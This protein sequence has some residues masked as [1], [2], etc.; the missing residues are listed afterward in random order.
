M[1]AIGDVV[2]IGV[3]LSVYVYAVLSVADARKEIQGLRLQ[4]WEVKAWLDKTRLD[5]RRPGDCGCNCCNAPPTTLSAK[6][7][8]IDPA[9]AA[10]EWMG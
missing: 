1:P 7:E 3:A 4:L 6:F 9:S 5:V 8:T 10:A 2:V